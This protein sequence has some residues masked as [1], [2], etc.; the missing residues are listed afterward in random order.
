[1]RTVYIS[2]IIFFI[3]LSET[4]YGQQKKINFSS[5]KSKG[6]TIQKKRLLILWDDV[7]FTNNKS[8]MHCDSAIYDR[9]DNSF[10]AYQNIKI[11][12]N[13]SLTLFGDSLHYIGNEQKAFMYGNVKVIT[14]DVFLEAPSL[15]FN[16]KN[17][18]AY[19][20]QGAFINDI[21]K[22]YKIRSKRGIFETKIK[23]IFFKE[24]VEL[25]HKDY[26]INSDTLIYNTS[27]QTSNII[28]E[29]QI[30]TE[31]STILCNKGW[32]NSNKN[33]SSLEGSIIIATNTYKFFA[34]SIFYNENTG[35]SYAE[36][37]VK[38][39]DDSSNII[40]EGEFGTHNEKIDS[41]HVWKN[42][43]LSQLDSVDTLKI[44]ADQFIKIGDSI[45]NE[46]FCFNNVIIDGTQLKGD[47]DSIYFN[48]TDSIMKCIVQP[49]IWMGKNQ[50]TGDKI[51]F[52]T[53]KGIIYKMFVE[54]NAM[55]ISEND[56]LHYDQIKG[57]IITS[58]FKKNK[59][60]LMNVDGDGKVIYYSKDEK[61][62]LITE[63]NEVTSENMNIL[64][65]E[66][67]ISRIN[68]L[69]SPKGLTEP[70]NE[71]SSS[72]FL[73]NFFIYP[74]RTY[75]EKYIEANGD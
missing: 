43:I 25:D 51:E 40:I 72:K 52:K 28:G 31:N 13:D 24:D 66:N 15:I 71:N 17:K 3:C 9:G 26:D 38:I 53:H 54:N 56:T 2:L 74:K 4:N 37:N 41:A 36:G 16:Q 62:S 75:Y 7:V 6:I 59:M 65:S 63:I 49:V 29:T 19:Y 45:R 23:T 55:I 50:V 48:E 64:I 69:S 68:F 42:A 22:G 27:S 44:Y 20:N 8:I 21:T 18:I 67:Q 34:D 14:E 11:N 61:D 10:I 46:I 33:Q 35:V 5:K 30:Q 47:C 73:D 32:F 39:I 70:L 58:F 57:E 60:Y 1:M 12:E